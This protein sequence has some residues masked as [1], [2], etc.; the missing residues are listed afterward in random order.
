[1][2]FAIYGAQGIAL[3]TYEAVHSL[4][5]ARRFRCF[6]V[7]EQKG[8]VSFLLGM[9]V[10]ELPAFASILSEEDKHN[11]EILIATPENVMLEIERGL[12]RAGLTFHVR[13]TSSRWAQLM[14][15]YYAGKQE[16]MPLPALPVGYHSANMHVFMAKF[17]KDKPLDGRYSMPEWVTPIQVGAVLCRER[18]ANL[19]DC[20]GENISEKN[21]NYSELTALYW[22]WKN[23]LIF[24]SEEEEWEYYGLV[25]YRRVLE[26][27]EDDVL[28][29][30]GNHVDVVLP[31][32]MP[33]EPD[34]GEH[35]KRY[36]KEE[37]WKAVQHAVMEVQPEYA[38]AFSEVLKQRY[39]YNY[40]IM[41]A[42]KNILKEYCNWLFPILFRVEELSIPKG[43]ERTDRYIGYVGETLATLYFMYHKKHLNIV[44]ACCQFLV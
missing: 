25:H 29:L 35:H 38:D 8:N 6:L 31:Y 3:G 36:L 9:P 20:D 28:R 37:D 22:I 10:L 17:F 32:P 43:R 24:P 14:S 40:N 21:G 42:R 39:F 18:V 1:M 27:T 12:D 7:T 5:P 13:L 26:F 16:Y 2:D 44:H 30:V 23:R 15:Y 33:Y 4:Y 41:L 34:I 19:L 11:I